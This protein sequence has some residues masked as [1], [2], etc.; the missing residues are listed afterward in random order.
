MSPPNSDL[1]KPT[2]LPKS[3][4][5]HNFFTEG[6]GVCEQCIHNISFFKFNDIKDILTNE[7]IEGYIE[8]V[9]SIKYIINL[10]NKCDCGNKEELIGF[11]KSPEFKEQLDSYR[12]LINLRRRLILDLNNT[13]LLN[14][15]R[16]NEDLNN[17]NLLN[18]NRYNEDLNKYE[19][20]ISEYNSKYPCL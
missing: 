11:L 5:W 17:T 3:L 10:I 20:S 14:K 19:S 7:F 13:N 6:K 16:Y 15:N 4:N 9:S 12:F 18:K 1:E 2:G 8:D